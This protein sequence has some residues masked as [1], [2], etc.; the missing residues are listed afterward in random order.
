[1]ITSKIFGKTQAGETVTAYT[2]ADGAAHATILDFGGIVQ[3]VVIPAK[4]G[5]P[6]DVILGY[7][8][9]AG[10]EMNGGYLG[11]LIGRFG[12]RI[13]AGKIC[14]DGKPYQLYLNDRGNHLH[15]GKEGFN[16]KMWRAER[17]NDY[18]LALT[19][20]SPDGEENYPGQLTV[21]VVYTFRG[22][23]LTIDYR[24]TTTRR[25]VLNLTNHAYFDLNGEQEGSVLDHILFLDGD[26]ITPTDPAMIP[27]GGFRDVAGT[28]FDFRTPKAIGRDIDA[29]DPDLKQGGGY[30]HCYILN[31]A[32]YR[33]YGRV[34]GPKTGITMRCFTD[35]PA[36]QFYSGNGLHQEGKHAYYGKRAGFCLE[37]QA[38]PN[39]PN[40][41]EYEALGS[42]YLSPGEVYSH[43]TAYRFE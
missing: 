22:N 19:Y 25:T 2:I 31:G 32:G 17:V 1:M 36:V 24:A 33:E 18:A 38:I 7:N 9:V 34:T 11:A 12:N 43:R 5:A 26:R 41:P 8:D 21:R 40:V 14:V 15:G 29:D 37:T 13:G 10:Y 3:S 23:E 27:Q 42:S 39:N 4:N 6:T 20:V 30:D 35:L 16:R 28:P